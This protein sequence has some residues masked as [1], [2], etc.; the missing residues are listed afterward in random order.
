MEKQ[1]P[2][3]FSVTEIPVTLTYP[4]VGVTL[5]FF[6]RPCLVREE[7]QMREQFMTLKDDERAAKNHAHNVEMLA[8]LM[9][10]E[11]DGVPSFPNDGSELS[12]RV[13]TFFGDESAM[14][15]K[16]AAEIMT[17]YYRVSQPLEF[18]RSF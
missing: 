8:R 18:F 7:Q 13:R 16:I 17:L 3:I 6:L 15:E 5:K 10:R 1:T 9:V 14:K 12:R 2:D 11:P 4:S